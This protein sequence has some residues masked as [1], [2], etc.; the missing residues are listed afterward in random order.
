MQGPFSFSHMVFKMQGIF[1]SLS[2]ECPHPCHQ[3]YFYMA[4]P[5][6]SLTKELNLSIVTL[7]LFVKSISFI[8]NCW[9]FLLP[10]LIIAWK[11]EANFTAIG[12]NNTL[13]SKPHVS[14]WPC[15][16]RSSFKAW[17]KWKRKQGRKNRR[18]EGWNEGRKEGGREKYRRK[19]GKQ[20]FWKT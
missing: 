7:R 15:H 4:F 12:T 10:S 16:L 11:R 8:I 14:L 13:C 5:I 3:L 1:S 17:I 9:I 19:K 20:P 18:K 6:C 2:T